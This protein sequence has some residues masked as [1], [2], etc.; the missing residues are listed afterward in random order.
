M[1]KALQFP[2]PRMTAIPVLAS[3]AIEGQEHRAWYDYARDD[4]RQA[5]P[6]LNAA[7]ERIA[8][9]LALF[10]PRVSVLRSVRWTVHYCRSAGGI[11]RFPYDCTR[12]HKLAITHWESTGE[13]RGPKTGPFAKALLGDKNALV[14]DGWMAVALSRTTEEGR[15]LGKRFEIQAVHRAASIRVR[16]VATYVG[17]PIA[18]TQAA[19]W[20]G[21]VKRT[22]VS[23][24]ALSVMEELDSEIPV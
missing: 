4:I 6:F 24:P 19:I 12:S 17:W 22:R 5:A 9:L 10:S 1:G 20:A 11:D 3:L 16:E 18:E 13:I 21:I 15:I 14:L 8:A 2:V 7:P 23:V